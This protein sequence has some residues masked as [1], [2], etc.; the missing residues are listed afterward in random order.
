MTA[1]TPSPRDVGG[2]VRRIQQFGSATEQLFS[3]LYGTLSVRHLQE[4]RGKARSEQEKRNRRLRRLLRQRGMRLERLEAILDHISEGIILQDLN[5]SVIETNAAAR[6]IIGTDRNLWNSEIVRLFTNFS[7]VDQLSAELTPLDQPR[8]LMVANRPVNAQ[9]VAIADS[10]GQRVGTLII[11]RPDQ[12]DASAHQVK[13]SLVEHISHELRTPLA[14]L[15]LASEMLIAAPEDA[16]PNRRMLE[17][18]SRNVDILD[19]MVNEMIDIAAMGSGLLSMQ[20]QAV[21]LEDMVMDLYD[22]YK[23]DIAEAQHEIQ[24]LFKDADRLIVQADPK[25][26]RW[27]ISNVLKNSIQYTEPNGRIYVRVGVLN[28]DPPHVF[29][30]IED[31][32]VGISPEDQAQVFN[33]FF[34]GKPRGKTGKLIDPRGL[35]QGLYV[36][37]SVAEAHGGSLRLRSEVGKGSQFRFLLPLYQQPVLM[38]D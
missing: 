4:K 34:R 20:V 27:A 38:A 21:L 12:P 32:G 18:I 24:I 31:T 17:L 3:R 30:D 33:L 36:A 23:D 5:G 16:P 25:Y 2:L 7:H 10:H 26:L 14:P 28:S 35:G 15:R 1:P 8:R 13:A 19:R 29:I 11:L 22:E 6:E 37:R 9:V